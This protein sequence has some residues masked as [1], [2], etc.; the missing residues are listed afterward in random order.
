MAGLLPESVVFGH[1][2]ITQLDTALAFGLVRD[3]ASAQHTSGLD[4][5]AL[6]YFLSALDD[7]IAG[8]AHNLGAVGAHCTRIYRRGSGAIVVKDR[9]VGNTHN[10]P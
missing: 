9:N 1:A 8:H 7:G 10:F 4:Y 2:A 5:R 3:V 6:V